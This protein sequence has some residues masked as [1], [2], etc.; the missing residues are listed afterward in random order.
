MCDD[1][2]RAEKSVEE[3]PDHISLVQRHHEVTR[4]SCERVQKK[5]SSSF[6]GSG[7]EYEKRVVSDS[8]SL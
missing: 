5:L 7:S 3:L 6:Q 1:L 2:Y 8:E 4:T